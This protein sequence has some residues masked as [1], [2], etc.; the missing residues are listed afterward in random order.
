M[1]ISRILVL[2]AAAAVAALATSV[3]Q[4]QD[5]RPGRPFPAGPPRI[6]RGG[7]VVVTQ[8][9]PTVVDRQPVRPRGE[10]GDNDHLRERLR[11]ACFNEPNP[12]SPLCRR[13]FGDHPGSRGQ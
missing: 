2:S 10:R 11:N 8:G 12:P 7:P 5:G 13:V 9:R 3:A 4:A 1:S 6:D